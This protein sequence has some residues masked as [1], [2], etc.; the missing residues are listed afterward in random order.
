MPR[1][2]VR[3]NEAS[4]CPAAK[5][6]SRAYLHPSGQG[7][8]RCWALILLTMVNLSYYQE[9]MAGGTGG[10]HGG[11]FEEFRHQT[12]AMWAQGDLPPR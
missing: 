1:I 12:Q 10:D 8:A 6:Y 5:D 3:W 2:R 4:P 9:L 11:R 7:P